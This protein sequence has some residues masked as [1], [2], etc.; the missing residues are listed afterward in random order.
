M[1]TASASKAPPPNPPGSKPK[2]QKNVS[3]FDFLDLAKPKGTA[4]K[5]PQM[6]GRGSGAGRAASAP[7]VREAASS[8][9]GGTAGLGRTQRRGKEKEGPKKVRMSRMKKAILMELV[10]RYKGGRG[11]AAGLRL[12]GYDEL[13]ARA[14][15]RMEEEDRGKDGDGAGKD[16]GGEGGAGGVEG[17]WGDGNTK[18]GS[19]APGGPSHAAVESVAGRTA[20]ERGADKAALWAGGVGEGTLAA[21]GAAEKAAGPKA[22]EAGAEEYA[23]ASFP[24]KRPA[25]AVANACLV[26]EYVDQIV[27]P[28][29]NDAA[30]ALLGEVQRFQVLGGAG[31]GRVELGGGVVRVQVSGGV[32]SRFRTEAP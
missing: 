29:I 3:L 2:P 17:D 24:L 4:S 1:R 16:T 8:V 11:E 28:C 9:G 27:A 19:V 14:E 7:R 30:K 12:P 15:A 5:G 13:W 32:E 26:R 6:A 20:G 23:V 25:E 31:A 22:A 10:D 21:E 18:G